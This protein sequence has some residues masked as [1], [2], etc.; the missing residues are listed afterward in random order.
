MSHKYVAIDFG[1]ESGRVML[2]ELTADGITLTEV[3]RFLNIQICVTHAHG[4][5]LHWDI[6]RLWHE[7]K[8]G[9]GK[10]ANEG[11]HV[12]GVGVDVWGVDFAL[13][14]ETGQLVGNP[15]CY[16]DPRTDGMVDAVFAKM[17]QQK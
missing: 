5:T 10:I 17:S 15:V 4:Q 12:E 6:L 7:V 11:H 13:L 14:D 1:A 8:T 3:H 9:L 16:R 2:G